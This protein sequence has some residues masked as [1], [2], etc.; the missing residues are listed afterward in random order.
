MTADE[1]RKTIR[2]RMDRM[3]SL[4]RRLLRAL[5]KIAWEPGLLHTIPSQESRVMVDSLLGTAALE[6]VE[7]RAMLTYLSATRE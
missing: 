2:A 7:R 1:V 3:S 4:E 6:G 5:A